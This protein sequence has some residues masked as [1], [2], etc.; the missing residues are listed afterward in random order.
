MTTL[1]EEEMSARMVLGHKTFCLASHL[2]HRHGAGQRDA[3]WGPDPSGGLAEGLR[4][5]R[6]GPVSGPQSEKVPLESQHITSQD[7][8]ACN[9]KI[10]VGL[11]LRESTE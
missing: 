10:N 8:L 7:S 9:L 1:G 3:G 11:N 2:G 6:A 5:P 4:R